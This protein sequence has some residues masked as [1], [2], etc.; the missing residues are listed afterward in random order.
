MRATIGDLL[1]KNSDAD[2][3]IDRVARGAVKES[4]SS[5]TPGQISTCIRDWLYV[6]R[7][8]SDNHCH[9]VKRYDRTTRFGQAQG[10]CRPSASCLAG[11][12]SR[13]TER[14]AKRRATQ[15][16]IEGPG[17]QARKP[18]WEARTGAAIIPPAGSLCRICRAAR[19]EDRNIRGHWVGPV[20]LGFVVVTFAEEA[21]WPA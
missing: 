15:F 11:R 17:F 8:A 2:R 4:P 21:H 14:P 7:C 3:S 12:E 1:I 6:C 18:A 5:A 10:N 9:R 16:T 20:S 13:E 19:L